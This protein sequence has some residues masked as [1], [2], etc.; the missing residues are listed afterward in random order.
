MTNVFN[1][2]KD[3]MGQRGSGRRLPD[4]TWCGQSLR[5][6]ARVR[7]GGRSCRTLGVMLPQESKCYKGSKIGKK[8][9]LHKEEKRNQCYCTVMSRGMNM[10]WSHMRTGQGQRSLDLN[11]ALFSRAMC[12]EASESGWITEGPWKNSKDTTIKLL[13]NWWCV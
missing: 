5:A 11:I 7:K 4:L 8:Q 10:V 3:G 9:Q 2:R 13:L 1:Q 6:E 12:P